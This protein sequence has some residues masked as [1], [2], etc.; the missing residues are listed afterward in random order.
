MCK[1]APA[2]AVWNKSKWLILIITL[3]VIINI[4]IYKN[5]KFWNEFSEN[6]FSEKGKGELKID[7]NN[8]GENSY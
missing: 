8:Q 5:I 3:K 7:L 4:L 2:L 6:E 1:R